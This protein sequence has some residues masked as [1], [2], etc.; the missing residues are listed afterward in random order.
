MSVGAALAT[1]F[2]FCFGG[3]IVG[4]IVPA[5]R[6]PG[7]TATFGAVSAIAGIVASASVLATGEHPYYQLWSIEPGE[8]LALSID[9]FSALFLLP[10]SAVMLASSVYS[11]G[12]LRRHVGRYDLRALN[13]WFLLLFASIAAVLLAADVLVFLLAWEAMS[14]TSYLLVA[15]ENRRT[16]SSGAAYLMLAMGEAGFIATA[17]VLVSLALHAG[18]PSLATVMSGV[19]GLSD[20]ARWML[21]LLAFFGFGV[22]AG[23]VP[24]NSWLPRAHPAA[25]ANVSA[26]LSGAILNLGLYGIVRIALPLAPTT[27]AAPGLLV[28]VVGT[29]SALIGI[30]YATTENDIK[31]LL[32][33]SSIENIGVIVVGLGSGMVFLHYG[34]ASLAAMAFVAAFYHMLNHSAYKSLLFLGAGAVDDRAGTRDLNRLGGLARAMPWTSAAM[35]V[36]ALSIAA[37]PPFNGFTSEWLTL[38]VLLRAAELEPTTTRL[39]FV[40][41]GAGLALAAALAVTC[42]VKM[43]GMGFLGMPRSEGASHA[44]EARPSSI[45]PM[46]GLAVACLALGV[47][48]AYVIGG[49][50]ESLRPLAEGGTDALVPPFFSAAPGHS[51]LP[52]AF[53]AEFHDLGAQVAEGWL[54]WRG[55]VVLHR[56]GSENPVVFAMSMSYALVVLVVLLAIVFVLVRGVLARGRRV[57][58]RER[59]AGGVRRLRPEMTYTATGFSNPVRVIFDAIFRP[60]TVVDAQETIAEHFRNAIRRE[61][62]HV[63]VVDRTVFLPLARV[64]MRLAHRLAE[65]HHGKINSYAAYVLEALALA[66]VAGLL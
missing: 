27:S 64:A 38:Q 47:L 25:P 45:A 58:R 29:L 59:W 16:A 5:R 36:G 39:V 14:V 49:L 66:L 23:L 44:K 8:P 15:F 54:P 28:L 21:F 30:L 13:A 37:L 33:H 40:L 60:T 57:D 24:F 3:A 19:A 31:A 6:A 11:A 2:A 41:C 12:Y 63:H 42:F 62:E 55:L 61:K 9:R 52:P 43:F 46:I 4:A 34:R 17:V 50:G 1:A 48:P 26:M 22:K 53:A 7:V 51:A 35:L 18:S 32:A 20:G 65:M 10:A 56:G